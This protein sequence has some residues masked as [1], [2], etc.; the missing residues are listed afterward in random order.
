M[1]DSSL[2]PKNEAV[3]WQAYEDAWNAYQRGTPPGEPA[4]VDDDYLFGWWSGVGDASAYQEGIVAG[5]IGVHFCPY[6]A[7][8]DDDCFRGPWLRGYADGVD[9]RRGE[10]SAW[11]F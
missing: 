6:A 4:Y 9:Y 2:A 7:G 5:Q 10:V 8:T 3:Y 11:T 1:N